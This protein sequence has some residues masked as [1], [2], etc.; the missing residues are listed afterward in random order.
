MA[1]ARQ[2]NVAKQTSNKAGQAG[3]RLFLD[4]S[5]I[6]STSYGGAKFWVLLVDDYTNMAF[7]IFVKKKSQ[8]VDLVVALIKELNQ[9]NKRVKYI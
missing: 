2:K 8:Q 1:K 3:E 9:N 6:K 5:Q 7:S 4:T